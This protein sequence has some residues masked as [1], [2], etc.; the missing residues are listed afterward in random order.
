MRFTQVFASVAVFLT[1]PVQGYY[2]TPA[3]T[4]HTE[5]VTG[6]ATL[7]K[8]VTD[9]YV[10]WCPEPTTFIHK[11]ATYTAP[12]PTWVTITNCPCTITYTEPAYTA[13]TYSPDCVTITTEGTVIT[14]TNPPT[15]APIP[16]VTTIGHTVPVPPTVT[17]P[18]APTATQ[19]S[20][21]PTVGAAN[22]VGAGFGAL[23][24]AG[25]AA[26]IM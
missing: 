12:G 15:N 21:V 18:V 17:Q 9:D 13:S 19:P 4:I 22:K 6:V 5:V 8:T 20:A 14:L 11:N 3:G 16:P 1:A 25:V 24:I 10:Y 26:L 7:T 23:A 2:P